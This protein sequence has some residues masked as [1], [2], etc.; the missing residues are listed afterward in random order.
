MCHPI[1]N[2]YNVA[3]TKVLGKYMEAIIVDSEKTARL[4]IQYL[5]DHMLDP[6]T[7]L[8]IDYLQ[9]KPLKERLRNISRPHN[10]KLMYDVLEFDPEIDR[11]VLFA[12]N[13]A[14][15]CESPEDANHV[16]YELERDG[17]YDVRFFILFYKVVFLIRLIN[18]I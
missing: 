8:P 7:F 9:T 10:V 2:R 15:V 14:L 12:T 13:N 16:A 17:R 1:S 18:C 4:C 6:E 11:V 5:K 3:I